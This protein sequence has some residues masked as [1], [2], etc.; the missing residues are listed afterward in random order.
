MF[1]R[2]AEAARQARLISYGAFSY[3]GTLARLASARG[4]GES[5]TLGERVIE[6]MTGTVRKSAQRW[7]QQLVAAGLLSFQRQ[8]AYKRGWF[9][10]ARTTII[11]CGSSGVKM[12]PEASGDILTPDS[13]DKKSPSLNGSPSQK[14]GTGAELGSGLRPTERRAA[15]PD[16]K[17]AKG[18]SVEGKEAGSVGS[19][20]PV[21]RPEQR[22]QTEDAKGGGVSP[23]RIIPH[24]EVAR[25][26]RELAERLKFRT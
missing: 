24:D 25:R 15:T 11:F 6:D 16:R 13:G 7:R 5:F 23:D 18:A 17:H 19:T 22:A 1:W 20:H 12:S 9:W 2:R 8:W 3:L 26:F 21:P 10:E 14:T 4:D